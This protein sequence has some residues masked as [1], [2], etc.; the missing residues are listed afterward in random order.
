M[1]KKSTRRESIDAKKTTSSFLNKFKKSEMTNNIKISK[2]E[3]TKK[4][5]PRYNSLKDNNNPPSTKPNKESNNIKTNSATKNV[6]LSSTH[7]SITSID[8]NYKNLLEEDQKQID[9]LKDKI[10]KQKHQMEE[11]KKKLNEMKEENEKM[12]DKIYN[13]NKE[14][15]KIKQEKENYK[16]LNDEMTSKINEVTRTLID[17]RNEMEREMTIRRRQL[18][19]NHLL[20]MLMGLERRQDDYP[21]VDNMTYE[22]LLA[23][24]E[25]I[26]NVKKGF[27]KEEIKKLPKDNFTR[28]KYSD[29]KC[30]ICQ[31][32]FKN[33]EEIIA[34]KC[35]HCFHP[36]CINQWLEDKKVCP[37][38]KSEIII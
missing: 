15:E 37:Y 21:N 24:E 17:R 11:N 34:L 9:E 33:Y 3:S 28:Y 5:N 1:R 7:I 32:E 29:D 26:G 20:L 13:K 35:K 18:I 30:I 22:E 31:Y 8:I 36:D 10:I 12:K 23:L 38:C 19:M 25:K 2:R 27:S 16:K 4:Y 14:L 6:T